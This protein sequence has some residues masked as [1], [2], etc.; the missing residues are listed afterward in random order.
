MAHFF[1]CT[2]ED[3]EVILIQC[4]ALDGQAFHV[5]QVIHLF[6]DEFAQFT[7]TDILDGYRL[8]CRHLDGQP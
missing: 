3:A 8:G 1:Q 5:A 7:G 6:Q 4:A 2:I